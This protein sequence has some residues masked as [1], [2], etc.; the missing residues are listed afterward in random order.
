V[1]FL[2]RCHGPGNAVKAIFGDAV[3]A[4]VQQLRL[5]LGNARFAPLC[6]R[7]ARC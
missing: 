3:Q 1:Y 5:V 6:M 4:Q 7:D 2:G